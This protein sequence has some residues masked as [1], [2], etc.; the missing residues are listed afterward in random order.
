M[1]GAPGER[2]GMDVLPVV[3]LRAEQP[4]LLPREKNATVKFAER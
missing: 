1:V 2:F 4:Q 3:V